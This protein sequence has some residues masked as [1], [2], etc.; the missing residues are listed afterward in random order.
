LPHR[1]WST[2]DPIEVR[3]GFLIEFLAALF[4]EV[5]TALNKDCALI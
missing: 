1:N 5:V 2:I 4:V 3:L